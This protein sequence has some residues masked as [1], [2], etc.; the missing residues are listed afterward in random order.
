MSKVEA[1]HRKVIL[2]WVESAI[3][4]KRT[5]AVKKY[6]WW[7]EPDRLVLH[8]VEGRTEIFPWEVIQRLTDEPA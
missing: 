2:R 7:Q 5:F 4:R 3:H 1:L 6:E 8:T